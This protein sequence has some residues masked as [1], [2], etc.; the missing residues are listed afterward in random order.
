M[1]PEEMKTAIYENDAEQARERIAQTFDDLQEKLSPRNL[2]TEAVEALQDKGRDLVDGA[3]ARVRQHPVVTAVVAA[4]A[5]AAVFGR[6]KLG[7]D[8]DY[9]FD[10]YE[11]VYG[12]DMNDGVE[13]A[14]TPAKKGAEPGVLS[15]ARGRAGDARDYASDKLAAARARTSEY[16]S[17]AKAKASDAKRRAGEGLEENPLAIA[18]VG[19]AAGALIGALLP[20][21]RREDEL[22]GDQRDKLVGAGKA[23]AKAAVDTAKAELGERGLTLNAAKAKL[24]E[25][26]GHARDVARSAGKAAADRARKLDD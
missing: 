16:A 22:L 19:V 2:A 14:P 5:G 17:R 13:T 21:T 25:V 10:A 24:D 4:A 11:D 26:G 18:L 7:K 20:R 3:T 8:G 6:R 15:R 9:K 23:A 12:G 1:R